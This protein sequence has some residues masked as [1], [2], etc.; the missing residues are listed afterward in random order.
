MPTIQQLAAEISRDAAEALARNAQAMPA[1]KLNWSALDAGRTAFQQ[2]VECAVIYGVG[3]AIFTERRMPPME[4][5]SFGKAMAALDTPEKA[6]AA[7]KTNSDALARAIEAF[8]DEHLDETIQLPFFPTPR[9]FAHLL[10]MP[11]WNSV[12][13]L[14]QIAFIQTL[15]GDKEMH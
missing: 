7:L 3:A 13:H 1:D 12:Y 10:L 5:D 9:S 6:L 8:P 4:P 15:Y 11:Y 14:G 2:I